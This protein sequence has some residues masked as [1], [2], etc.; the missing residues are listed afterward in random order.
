Y[1]VDDIA[2]AQRGAVIRGHLLRQAPHLVRPADAEDR[3][4]HAGPEGRDAVL[5][6]PAELVV[7]EGVYGALPVLSLG[8]LALPVVPV[9]DPLIDPVGA[10]AEGASGVVRFR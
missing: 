5:H 2:A 7:V 9:L 6:P 10:V 1:L 4:V 8:H 3:P